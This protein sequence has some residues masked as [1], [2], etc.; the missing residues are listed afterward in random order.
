MCSD[1]TALN[2]DVMSSSM[3]MTLKC[4]DVP[5]MQWFEACQ[6]M[7]LPKNL[8]NDVAGHTMSH[9]PPCIWACPHD[10]SLQPL[11]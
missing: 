10:W 7:F 11:Y 2:N 5:Q 4:Y 9:P 8:K 6:G 3:K 1:I